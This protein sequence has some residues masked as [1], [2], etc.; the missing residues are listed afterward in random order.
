MIKRI[1]VVVMAMAALNVA[2]VNRFYMSDFVIAPGE[3]MQVAMILEND[4]L[5][6]AFQTD[7]MLPEGLSVVDEDGEYLFDLTSRNAS[8]QTIISKLRDDGA[9]RM[10]SFCMTVRPYSGNSGAIVVINLKADEEFEAPATIGLKN[11]FFTTVEGVEFILPRS[12]CQVQLIDKRLKG[13]ANGDG[14]VNISDVTSLI[15]YL[16]AGCQTSFHTENADMTDDGDI[17]ISDVTA[18]IDFL[19]TGH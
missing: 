13:D 11:S 3:T 15:D 14:L 5:F 1:L 7:L 2:A 16:L 4:E 18:M 17:N 9:L 12:E 6:T 10:V 19:L 8:D